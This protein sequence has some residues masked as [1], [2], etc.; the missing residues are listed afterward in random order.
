MLLSFLEH[1]NRLA[2]LSDDQLQETHRWFML[3]LLKGASWNETTRKCKGFL[4][5]D[6]QHLE[7]VITE[8]LGALRSDV[9]CVKR[10]KLAVLAYMINGNTEGLQSVNVK[11][12]TIDKLLVQDSQR[13]RKVIRSVVD[14]NPTPAKLTKIE[15]ELLPDL[16]GYTKNF[17]YMNARFLTKAEP[18]LKIEDIARQIEDTTLIAL[19][20]IYPFRVGLHLENTL[21]ASILNKG[22]TLITSKTR[23]KS[24]RLIQEADGTYSSME[25]FVEGADGIVDARA[26]TKVTTFLALAKKSPTMRVFADYVNDPKAQDAFIV[27]A[28]QTY[29]VN[30]SDISDLIPKLATKNVTYSRSLAAYL[31]LSRKDVLTSLKNLR[32]CV[33]VA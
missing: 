24:Q 30:A 2:L 9:D 19:R 29:K 3:Y 10:L 11:P 31:G 17:A 16:W 26:E 4:D 23:Q 28:N 20:W 6:Q 14:K 7:T 33:Y 25:S 21:K 32:E 27:W 15:A 22:N 13:Y 5:D 8:R 1:K 12:R 18:G